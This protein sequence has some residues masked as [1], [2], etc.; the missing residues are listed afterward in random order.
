MRIE[1]RDVSFGYNG[2]DVLKRLNITFRKGG[3]TGIVGP[4]GSGKTTLIKLLDRILRPRRGTVLL[5]GE[6]IEN[7]H[8]R[9]LARL[10]GYVPQR[11]DSWRPETVFNTVLLGRLP[12]MRFG[13]ARRDLRIVEDVLEELGI[14][15]I[16][17]RMT[18][19]LSGGQRQT[20]VIARALAQ[21]PRVLLLDEPTASLDI[22]HRLDM[23]DLIRKQNEA[24]IT[25]IISMHDLNLAAR[26][27]RHFVMLKD[28]TVRYAGG[29]DVLTPETI[30]EIY[31]IEV[32]IIRRNGAVIVHPR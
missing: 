31:D 4:N 27:C 3:V 19:E 21:N 14:A 13:P 1:M 23:L 30:R 11:L 28:G 26:Y 2:A 16:S 24:G 5:D 7:I 15:A 29:R 12:Y 9:T 25:S 17:G 8:R 18:N 6:D 10:I 22:R 32:E 20:V